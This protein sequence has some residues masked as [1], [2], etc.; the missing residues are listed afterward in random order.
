M[1]PFPST[2]SSKLSQQAQPAFAVLF[3]VFLGLS[4]LKFGNPPIMEKWVSVPTDVY[5]FLLGHPWPANW[6]YAALAALAA[7]GVCSARWRFTR[8]AWL[9]I[10]PLLW[11]GW[12]VLASAHTIQPELTR[13]TLH[14]F[15][16]CVTCFYLG[17]FALRDLQNPALFGI[18]LA[19]GLA[20][21]IAAGWDQHFGGLEASRRYFYLYL[22]PTVKNLPPEY[23]KRL[24]SSRIFSTLF[25]PNALA[26][27]LLLV[28]PMSVGLASQASRLMTRPARWFLASLLGLGGLACLYWSGSKGGWLLAMG[29]GFCTL[30]RLPFRPKLKAL[31]VAVVLVAGL[32]GFGWKYSGFFKKGSTSV[33][34]RFDYWRAALQTAGEHPVWGTGPGTFAIPYA[35]IKRPESEMARLAHNDYLEQASDS[36]I[37]GL[38]LYTALV[39]GVLIV[40]KPAGTFCFSRKSTPAAS[41]KEEEEIRIPNLDAKRG[42]SVFY[43]LLWLGVLGWAIQGQFEFGLYIPALS[44]AAFGFMGLL[45]GKTG[46][47]EPVK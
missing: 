35:Q 44:W 45:L 7:L 42:E 36:G 43:W 17:Y 47:R 33:V 25:Y 20:L 15:F 14:H 30:L 46:N 24:N 38:L 23:L 31:L 21:V 32:L 10:T 37:P 3:G 39:G 12:Q 27:A 4:L 16:A 9:L 19:C 29:L 8:P 28:L 5:E 18:G 41:G 26:G 34:A 6:A 40:S 1:K 22:Y 11:L 2:G 13:P